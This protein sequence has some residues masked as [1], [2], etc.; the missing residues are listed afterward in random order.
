MN[1][2]S[3]L[4]PI[5]V[6]LLFLLG[7]FSWTYIIERYISVKSVPKLKNTPPDVNSIS[8]EFALLFPEIE[9]EEVVE[10]NRNGS[11][12][13]RNSVNIKLR[14]I[15]LGTINKVIADVNGKSLILSEGEEA[16]GIKLLKV[17]RNKAKFLVGGKERVVLLKVNLSGRL[18]SRGGKLPP[19]P[20]PRPGEVEL[21]RKEIKRITKDPGIMFREIRLVPYVRKGKTEGFIFEWIKPGS[22]FD[23]VGLKKGDILISINNMNIKS[24]EDAFRILQTL[25][26]APSLKVVVL[27]Q[28]RRE[29]ISIR[30]D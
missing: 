1:L 23:K 26:N 15:V 18:A 4:L 27:R 3:A 29:E 10:V 16:E 20:P 25:R 8:R 12:Q 9:R 24:G 13:R 30:I 2:L 5:Y 11:A 6:A 19:P 14:G 22:L 17:W 28:G 7:A 21:S